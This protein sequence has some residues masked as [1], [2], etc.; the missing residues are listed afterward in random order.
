MKYKNERNLPELKNLVKH[1]PV[2]ENFLAKVFGGSRRVVRAVDGVSLELRRGEIF[3]LVGESG[4]GKTTL[5]RTALR[6]L[7]PTSGRILFDGEEITHLSE[8]ELRPYRRRMQMVFQDPHAALNPAMTLGEAI[9]HPLKI[10]F[11]ISNANLKTKVL[12]ILEEVGLHPAENYFEKYPSD[13]SGGEKQRAVIARAIILAPDLVLLDEPVAMLDMSVRA[14]ILELLLELR[15]VN[16]LTYLFVT[17]DLATAKFICDRVGIL[18]LGRMV[19]LGETEEV[20][21][22][23]KHPYTQA[24]LEA[25]PKPDPKEKREKVLLKGEI[26]DAISPPAGCPFHPRC[27]KVFGD[28]GWEGRDLVNLLEE[29]WDRMD[30]EERDL[31]GN[32]EE[33]VVNGQEVFIPVAGGSSSGREERV[34]ELLKGRMPQPMLEALEQLE[35]LGEHLVLRFKEG[36][37][38]EL[39]DEGRIAVACHLY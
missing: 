25:I 16:N 6:L 8:N 32:L 27:P 14:K 24:L 39:K 37:V 20:F 26:P 1:F 30:E 33:I 22:N 2:E 29:I 15:K 38:P 11:K 13:L 21:R 9:G 7:E 18:Y 36:E 5:A 4:S 23:P 28:C 17:H 3:G 19:E 12:K 31:I 35:V 34:G 10:H